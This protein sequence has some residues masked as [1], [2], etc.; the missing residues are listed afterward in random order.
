V[1]HDGDC[2]EML[3][4]NN[5]SVY[6]T[7]DVVWLKRMYFTQSPSDDEEEGVYLPIY[8]PTV[9]GARESERLATNDHD[10]EETMTATDTR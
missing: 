1:D 4:V 7:R 6:V 3:D 5:G 9:V 2:Y 10:K 8:L